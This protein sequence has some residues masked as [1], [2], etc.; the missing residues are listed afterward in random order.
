AAR[1]VDYEAW[2][3]NR[4]AWGAWGIGD[5]ANAMVRLWELTRDPQYLAHLKSIAETTLR[6]R[7]DLHPGDDYPNRDNPIC[8]KCRPPFIDRERGGVQAAWGSGLYNDYVNGGALNPVDAVTSG[9]YLYPI[10]AFARLVLEDAS[11]QEQHGGAAMRLASAGREAI[12][13]AGG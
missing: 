3:K 2:M 6:Y 5:D 1:I 8:M 4:Q 7:D 10:V 13:S 12:Q 11:L 9:V